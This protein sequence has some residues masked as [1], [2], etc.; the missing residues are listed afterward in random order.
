MCKN[1]RHHHHKH[2]G[3]DEAEIMQRSL[4]ADKKF[5]KKASSVLYYLLCL[6]AFLV[7]LVC[8]YAYVIDR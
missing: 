7:V 6:V 1:V 8:I 4:L 5:R 2:D 3:L